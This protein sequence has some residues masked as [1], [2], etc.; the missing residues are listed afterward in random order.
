LKETIECFYRWDRQRN[1]SVTLALGIALLFAAR[2][3]SSHEQQPLVQVNVL[4]S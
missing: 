4:D 3:R 1:E 2:Q